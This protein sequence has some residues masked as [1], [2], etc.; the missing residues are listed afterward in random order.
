MNR[1]TTIANLLLIVLLIYVSIPFVC[2]FSKAYANSAY[3][4]P[5]AYDLWTVGRETDKS[6][7]IYKYLSDNGYIKEG[8]LFEDFDYILVLTQQ[9]CTMTKHVKPE[10][11]LAMIAVESNFDVDAKNGSARGLMQLI[12]IYHSARMQVYT[13]ELINLDHFFDPR[14]NIMT[15][16]DYLD[17]ILEST[18]GNLEYALMWYNQGPISASKD[19]LDHGIVSFYAQ[20]ITTISNH[21]HE[22]LV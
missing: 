11:A 21:I 13:E 8:L 12:P 9:L 19:Y 22:L 16:L 10:V 15:G 20:K 6:F 17:Y 18:D 3:K 5:D 1:S 2:I 14:L 7:Y 4:A